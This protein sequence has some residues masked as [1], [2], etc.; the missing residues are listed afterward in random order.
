MG[1]FAEQVAGGRYALQRRLGEGGMATVWLARDLRHDR[2]VALKIIR[3]ELAGAIGVDRFLREIQLTAR[4]QHPNV[5]PLVD[6]GVLTAPDG[7]AL[8]WYAMP[9][10][11]GES[12]RARLDRERQL[13]LEDALRITDAV[14]AALEA[15]HAVQVVHRDIKPENV[16]LAAGHVYVVD[17]GIAKALI[18]TGGERITSTGLSIG[19]PA[20]MSPEQAAGD[21]VDGRSD[22]YSLA[23]VLY[24]MLTGDVPFA[25]STAQAIIARRLA[26]PARPLRPVRPTVPEPL[27]R[28]VLTALE[29]TPADRFPSVAAFVTALRTAGT[30]TRR[31]RGRRVLVAL[32]ALVLVGALAVALPRVVTPRKGVGTVSRDSV[33]VALYQRGMQ[34]LAKR[35]EEGA[36]DAL[37][38]FEGAIARDSSWGAA[39]AGL[40]QT[41]QQAVNRRFVF[42]GLDAD[43]VL[44]L[45][46]AA[47]DRAVVLDGHNAQVLF[48]QA[49]LARLVDPTNLT[50]VLKTLQQAVALDPRSSPIWLRLGVTLFDLG[51]RDEA[52]RAWH[53]AIAID[54]THPEAIAFLA[55]GFMWARQ[56]DS[57]AFWSDSAI[58]VNPNYL[59]ARSTEGFVQVERGN[60]QRAAAAFQAVRRLSAGVEEPNALAGAALVAA[61]AGRPE[62]AARLM[63]RVES[64]MASYVPVPAHNAVY[65][66][67]AYAALGD[68]ARAV[69]WLARY[70]PRED[71]HFQVHLRCDPSLDPIA[72]A[73]SFQALLMTPRPGPRGC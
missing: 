13:P 51:R 35:T 16:L 54:P 2:E 38:S 53:R 48:A 33:A 44:R 73:A 46:V 4:L 69:A 59:L 60:I 18:D 56:Y 27:E 26:E 64:L 20:Y 31:D 14:A 36:R 6:S 9:Y 55:L 12:L 67:E 23:T 8:P 49:M 43:S 47:I 10:L 28:A 1:D 39:W 25:A 19:T 37:A 5:V 17:F 41:Y 70:A 61:R 15:A 32:G 11:E 57:A 24:E 40:A 29:R 72:G 22:Q 42:S 71:Q 62:E 45:A 21:P 68:T 34:G 3:P 65:N 30:P 7:A 50:P 52:L 66:A 63:A 58:V